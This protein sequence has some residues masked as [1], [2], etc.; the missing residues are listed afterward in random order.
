MKIGT[1]VECIDDRFNAEQIEKIPNRPKKGNHYM[2]REIIELGHLVGVLLEEVCNPR[3]ARFKGIPVE[4]NF[5]IER[6]R[7]IEGLD[8]LY[9]ELL[10]EV[11]IKDLELIEI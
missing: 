11:S 8:D 6:F 5:N 10:E 9:D 7:E 3:V 1:L 4:P 2:I